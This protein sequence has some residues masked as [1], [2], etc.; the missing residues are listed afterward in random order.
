MLERAIKRRVVEGAIPDGV[1]ETNWQL[2]RAM[3][4]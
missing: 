2:W 3:A 4:I 1:E